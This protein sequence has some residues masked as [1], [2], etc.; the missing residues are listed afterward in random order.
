MGTYQRIAAKV[1]AVQ[2]KGRGETNTPPVDWPGWMFDAL[3]DGDIRR[4]VIRPIDTLWVLTEGGFKDCE[5]GGWVLR[6]D[7]KLRTMSDEEFRAKYEPI[8]ETN[9]DG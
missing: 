3:R 4:P 9:A 5:V 1:E 7:G 2:Y 8:E 6:D